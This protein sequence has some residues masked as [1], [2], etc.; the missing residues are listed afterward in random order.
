MI[1][2]ENRRIE[3]DNKYIKDAVVDLE[4]TTTFQDDEIL[5]LTEIVGKGMIS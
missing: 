3:E 5:R 4:Y 2:E 1:V